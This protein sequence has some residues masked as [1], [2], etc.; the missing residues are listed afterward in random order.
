MKGHRLETDKEVAW[1]FLWWRA[2]IYARFCSPFLPRARAPGLN[3]L[4]PRPPPPNP[5]VRKP[6]RKC[7]N[8]IE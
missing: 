5:I 3:G 1:Q 7:V 8:V 2:T 6:P 4:P